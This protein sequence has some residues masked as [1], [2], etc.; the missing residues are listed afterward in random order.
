MNVDECVRSVF[1]AVT[2]CPCLRS[3][4]VDA[5]VYARRLQRID[6]DPVE[7]DEREEASELYPQREEDRMAA[8]REAMDR[9]PG[10]EGSPRDEDGGEDDEQ[11]EDE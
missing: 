5:L 6:K 1:P 7:E 11:D 10:D 8:E 4:R 9:P 3:G 2:T